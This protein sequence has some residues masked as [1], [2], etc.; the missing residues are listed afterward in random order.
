MTDK[1]LSELN[2]R[3][4]ALEGDPSSVTRETRVILPPIAGAGAGAGA[5]S[6]GTAGCIAMQVEGGDG[7]DDGGSSS[8]SGNQLPRSVLQKLLGSD[9]SSDTPLTTKAVRDLQKA[10]KER[11]YDRTVIRVR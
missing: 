8:S 6:N 3:R 2:R 10:Q 1:Q 4:E 9:G 7:D 11:V 5:S